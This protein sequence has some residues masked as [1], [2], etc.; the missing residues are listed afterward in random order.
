MKTKVAI[1][2]TS[3]IPANYGGFETMVH[4]L[5]DHMDP[6][7]NLS[8]YCSSKNYKKNKR[9]KKWKGARLF[10]LPLDAN[11]VSSILYDILSMIH[12]IFYADYLLVLG[13]SGGIFLPFLKLFTNKKIIVNIDGLEWKRQKWG[14][15]AQKFLKFSERLA[16]RY[17]H[18]DITD[19]EAI[20]SYTAEEYQTLSNLIEYG[21]DHAKNEDIPRKE[22][23]SSPIFKKYPELLS[24]GYAFK[25]ARI[26]PENNIAEILLAFS[27]YQERKL[28]V[29]GNWAH[30]KYGLDIR[31]KYEPYKNIYLID[32][33][34]NQKELNILRSN[35]FLYIHGHSAGGT[36]PSL[37]EAMHLQLP[38]VAFD[39]TFNR[40][41]TEEVAFYFSTAQ[42]LIQLLKET[43][44]KEYIANSHT[45]KRI[46]D[47]RYT[48]NIIA[49][50]LELLL[51]SVGM[52]QEKKSVFPRFSHL[53]AARL[54]EFGISHLK[55]SKLFY[56]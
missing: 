4:Q 6:S 53:S 56:E 28:V 13:V 12:A 29:V 47:H 2:G 42:D 39:V 11:G 40:K 46:A 49:N 18:A 51:L 54:Q 43:S 5:V 23:K 38:I 1:I 41:T 32:P 21:A 16:V 44:Y 27:I 31:E 17:S 45:M 37:I 8:V 14:K 20:K 55:S 25:V 30:S 26:E 52:N 15:M 36:N 3:G 50:K 7:W 9:M 22:V 33:I 10:Y 35:C 24:D 48:W 19:N 34:Y